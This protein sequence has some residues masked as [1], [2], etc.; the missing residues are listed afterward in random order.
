MMTHRANMIASPVFEDDVDKTRMA[1]VL[2]KLL[3]YTIVLLC[4][5]VITLFCTS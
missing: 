4:V 5:L 1:S 2:H 3:V